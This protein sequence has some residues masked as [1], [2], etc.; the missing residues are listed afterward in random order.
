MKE[1]DQPRAVTAAS[2][3]RDRQ[4][5]SKAPRAK[6]NRKK[7]ENDKNFRLMSSSMMR[8]Q[9]AQASLEHM[10]QD[11]SS[12][13]AKQSKSILRV[14]KKIEQIENQFRKEFDEQQRKKNEVVLT[15][16]GAYFQP[17]LDKIFLCNNDKDETRIEMSMLKEF[18]QDKVNEWRQ[19][20]LR[21]RD[22]IVQ[23]IEEQLNQEVILQ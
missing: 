16:A 13:A 1:T 4:W 2:D 10:T 6:G 22:Q 3:P 19:K 18:K 14:R 21:E 17:M 9:L 12:G 7:A 11:E 20:V 8:M 23:R 15:Q 5:L